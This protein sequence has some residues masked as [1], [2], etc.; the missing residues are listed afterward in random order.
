MTPASAYPPPMPRR[1]DEFTVEQKAA[2]EAARDA[3][4]AFEQA[5]RAHGVA[6]AARAAAFSAALASGISYTE[7]ADAFGWSRSSVQRAELGRG[8]E[9]KR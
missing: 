9:R 2:L 1:P 5:Q 3:Q 8:R 6:T 4:R 7:L